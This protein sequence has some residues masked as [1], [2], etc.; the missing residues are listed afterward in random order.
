MV[1]FKP[2]PD[3]G[4]SLGELSRA[5]ALDLVPVALEGGFRPLRSGR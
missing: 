4:C 2:C 1:R 3:R 5:Q